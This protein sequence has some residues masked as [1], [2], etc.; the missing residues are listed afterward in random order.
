MSLHEKV[1]GYQTNKLAFF[2]TSVLLLPVTNEASDDQEL[3]E[4]ESIC[5]L[6]CHGNM[7]LMIMTVILVSCSESTPS[8]IPCGGSFH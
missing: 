6:L 8:S 5:L 4:E 3:V 2:T 7:A 1:A